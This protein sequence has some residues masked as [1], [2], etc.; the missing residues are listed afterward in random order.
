MLSFKCKFIISRLESAYI[1]ANML[2]I[3]NLF[4]FLLLLWLGLMFSSAHVSWS[5]LLFGILFS[6]LIS[7]ASYK[8]KL[9]KK[10]SE[11]LYLS[12]GFYRYFINLYYKNFLKSCHLIFL[13]AL[14]K[15][16]LRPLIYSIPLDS[17]KKFNPALMVSS[18]NMS[19]GLFCV[20]I[21]DNFFYVHAIEEKY[22]ND[23]DQFKIIKKLPEINDDNLV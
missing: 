11:L 14:G 4:L 17:N 8:L 22:F 2:N 13:L 20:A 23:F 16:T 10:D 6:S 12:L 7:F 15:K 9:I 18:I 21:K 3:F 19:A 5:Y 1:Q